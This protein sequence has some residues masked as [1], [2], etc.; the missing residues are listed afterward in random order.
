MIYINC[1]TVYIK[2]LIK[3]IYWSYRRLTPGGRRAIFS[4]DFQM[5]FCVGDNCWDE[6]ILGVANVKLN[7]IINPNLEKKVLEYVHLY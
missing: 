2:S 5:F 7:K 4:S 1:I 6:I 3:V